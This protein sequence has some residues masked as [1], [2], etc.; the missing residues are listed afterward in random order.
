MSMA[1]RDPMTCVACGSRLPLLREKTQRYCSKRCVWQATKGAAFNARVARQSRVKRS[2]TQ[3][4]RGEGKSYQKLM[5]RHEHRLVAE[6]RLGRSL[7][8]GEIVHHADGNKR[9]NDPGNLEVITQAEHM[10]R[11]GLAIPGRPRRRPA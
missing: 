5:G 11:H 4:G 3:R 7:L 9:N 6:S 1:M 2:L 8:K 10:R